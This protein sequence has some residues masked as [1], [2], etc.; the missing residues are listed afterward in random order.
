MLTREQAQELTARVLKFSSFPDCT[1]SIDER[2][3]AYVRFA[4]NGVTTSAFMFERSVTINSV[5]DGKAGGSRTTDLSN[6]ALKAAVHRS[7]ELAQFS[8]AN[9]EYVEPL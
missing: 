1:A 7:E 6:D 8:P 2:E 4:N 5:R 3:V 9:P